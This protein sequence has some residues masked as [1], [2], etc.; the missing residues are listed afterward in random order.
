MHRSTA[1]RRSFQLHRL[2]DRH[3][4]DQAGPGGAPFDLLQTGL[5]KLILPFKCKGVP[6]KFGRA[7]QRLSVCNI[8]VDADQTVRGHVIGSHGTGKFHNRIRHALTSDLLIFHHVKALA[9]QP[10]ELLLPG[11]FKIHP[12]CAHQ[13]KRI[14]IHISS[15]CDLI[16]Q[17]TDRAAAQIPGIFVSG[18]LV[19]DLPVDFLKIR[20]TDDRLAS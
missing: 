19:L 20:I 12:C 8:L 6:G 17:L 13:G 15:G 7:P 10:Q 2:E 9:S 16:V 5:P 18:G 14:E 1:D 3:R 11:I 4:I